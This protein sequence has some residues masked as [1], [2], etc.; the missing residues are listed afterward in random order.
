MKVRREWVWLSGSGFPGL[1]KKCAAIPAR[2]AK[3][4]IAPPP[5]QQ[6]ALAGVTTPFN[7]AAI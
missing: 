6:M 5:S 1:G 2:C 7:A 3:S 4:T